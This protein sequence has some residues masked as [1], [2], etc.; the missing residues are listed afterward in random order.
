M[1]SRRIIPVV[2]LIL[3]MLSQLTPI[4]SMPVEAAESWGEIREA[5]RNLNVRA[6][7]DYKSEHIRTLPKGE[8]VKVD[9]LKN[10]WYAIFPLD[11]VERTES[12]AIGYSKSKYL[13]FVSKAPALTEDTSQTPS[14]A[15]SDVIPSPSPTTANSVPNISSEG[16][17][18]NGI[19]TPEKLI[20]SDVTVGAAIDTPSPSADSNQGQKVVVEV[21]QRPEDV[22]PKSNS[23][24]KPPVRI[25]A[26]KLTYDD[27]RRT[28]A[29]SGS[30]EAEHEGL[31]LW[32]SEVTA[33]FSKTGKPGEE[34]DR[35]VASGGVRMQRGTTEGTSESVTYL[36]GD[37][38]LLMEG[39]PEIRDGKNTVTGKVIKFYVKENRSEVVGGNGKRVEAIL[40]APGK[41]EA[42]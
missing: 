38:L 29:F 28:V 17:S 1:Q 41:V 15:A 19:V 6:K 2:F 40:F 14:G 13:R 22:A 31:Q 16:A 23:A 11:A 25:T 32:A 4:W 12:S 39:N 33:Y 36:V 3:V 26:D 34:I 20:A 8:R 42:P 18:S 10:G 37:N 5:E 9:F 7:R 27:K 30:V 35:V 21:E 24:G